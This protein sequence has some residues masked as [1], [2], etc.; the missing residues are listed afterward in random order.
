MDGAIT[1]Y[2][3]QFGTSF[4][5]S[6]DKFQNYYKDLSQRLKKRELDLVIVVNMFLTGFDATT[7]NTLWADKNLRA[8]GLIQAYS[9]TNRILNSVKTYGNIVSFRDLEQETNDALALFGNKDAKG[10]VL[11]K[12]YADYYQ[13][14]QQKVTELVGTFPLGG[15]I[16]GE[17]AEKA[18]I[19]LFGALLRL[20]N[21]LTA[22]DEF[23]GHEIL[24]A[25]DFQDYQSVY[26]DLYADFRSASDTDKESINDDVVFEIELIKQVEINVDYILMLVE[27]YL[28][29]K[30]SGSDRE[31]RAT[32]DRAI[33]A[34]P[35]LR[36][37]KD[38]IEQFVDS[39]STK[40]R[41]DAQWQSFVAARK[42]KELE[43]I[44]VDEGLD[45]EATRAFVDNAFRD[46]AIPT[47]GTAITRILPAVSRFS[48]NNDHSIKKQTVLD[49][50]SA[51]LE[52]F[53][54]LV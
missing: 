12:P 10:I 37:K 39:V 18:F 34:S 14:Y 36:N 16:V 1:D 43:R 3:G 38:L 5:T 7:L 8:H 54:G 4:D 15:P 9:R 52:R 49:K 17:A 6:S 51:F 11:L 19:R 13:E 45:A 30:G 25:R 33:N 22:F 47:T 27:K 40:A 44:I 20:R 31:I 41:V 29:A 32:I 26:L 24:S 53:L 28:K 35:S 21:I 2:N 50:L 48:K 23:A 46:G 42:A